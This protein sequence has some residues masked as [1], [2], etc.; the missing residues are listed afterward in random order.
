MPEQRATERLDSVGLKDGQER[1]AIA[2]GFAFRTCRFEN[3]VEEVDAARGV[4]CRS[5]GLDLRRPLH[6]AR[7]A[8]AAFVEETLP[9]AQRG[10]EGRSGWAAF[11]SRQPAV[12][13]G[14]DHQ[15]VVA[16][17]Q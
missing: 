6:D 9:L 4:V 8:N 13:A 14:E 15:R 10:V 16:Q 12:V 3:R 7:D 11:G 1:M 17:L 5:A 2:L